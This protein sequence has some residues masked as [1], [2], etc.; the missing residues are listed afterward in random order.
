[1]ITMP[2]LNFICCMFYSKCGPRLSAEA[3]EKL[4]N[5]YVLM[6]NN[7]ADYERETGKRVSIP[8]TV[9]Y[10][11]SCYLVKSQPIQ[12]QFNFVCSFI[13]IFYAIAM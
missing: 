4:K 5:R 9:R 2:V 11:N 1:M 6:R 10:V 3:A 7:A 12:L 13:S 8:I